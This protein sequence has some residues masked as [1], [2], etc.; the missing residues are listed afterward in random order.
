MFTIHKYTIK[1][2]PASLEDA[3]SILEMPRGG[4]PLKVD[5]QPQADGSIALC[6]WVLVMP[7][8]PKVQ[9]RVVLAKTGED[10]PTEAIEKFDHVDTL[11]YVQMR[12][13]EEGNQFPKSIVTH[14]FLEREAIN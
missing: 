2:G 9:R 10:L 13:D 4:R 11:Q 6:L 5:L 8:Q 14:V 3:A 7:S 12:L 1:E